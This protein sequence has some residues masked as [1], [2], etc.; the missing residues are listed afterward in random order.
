MTFHDVK[1]P[2][3]SEISFSE[4]CEVVVMGEMARLD[5]VLVLDMS[6][7]EHIDPNFL[8]VGV[9]K[10]VG[11]VMMVMLDLMHE[12]TPMLINFGV[13]LNNYVT[14]TNKI[15]SYIQSIIY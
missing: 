13:Y 8:D 14:H 3:D 12:M 9:F 15:I 7:S 4:N 6:G 2:E 1:D 10:H 5:V 11:E